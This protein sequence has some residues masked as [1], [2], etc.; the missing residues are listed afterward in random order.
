MSAK[1]SELP[2]GA[3]IVGT[4]T[5]P[6]VQS[7]ATVAFTYNQVKT[8]VLSGFSANGL[9]LGAAANYAAMRGLLDLEAGTDFNAYSANLAALSAMGST[10]LMARTGSGTYAART[11]TAPAAGITVTD[12]DG[13]AGNPTLAL[14]N[15]LAA[16]EALSGTNTIYYRSAANTWTAVTIGSG[17]TFSAGS[18]STTGG[19][20]VT[21]TGALTL[22][23]LVFG[24]GTD[25]LK[26]G[27]LT[28]D[29][30]TSGGTATT[31]G[32]LKVATGMI[33]AGAVTLAKIANA[34]A[35]SKLLGSGAAGSGSAYAELTL[36]TGLSFS[37]TTLNVSGFA[38]TGAITGSGLTMA[39][40]KL[41]G[42]GTASTGA[43][44]EITLGSNLSLSGT[45][46]NA[47]ASGG[48]G[49]AGS[50][51]IDTFSADGT[52]SKPS[53]A[54]VVKVYVLGSGGA[55]GSGAAGTNASNR[56][57][58]GGGAGGGFATTEFNASDLGSSVSV[59]VGAGG[60]APGGDGNTSSFG[61]FLAAR[62]GSGGGNGTTSGGSA[63]G[64]N[65]SAG[66]VYQGGSGAAGSNTGSAGSS[67]ATTT[68]NQYAGGAGG[69]GGG[70][71]ST[72]DATG[73][74]GAGG[75]PIW[76][77]GGGSTTGGGG[78]GGVAPT[79]PGTAGT[80]ADLSF[81]P[82][83]GGGGGAGSTTTTGGA[84]G[85]GGFGAGGG[86]GGASRSAGGAGGNGGP[87]RVWVVTYF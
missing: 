56:G 66:S 47:V 74:G 86:G 65:G 5:H 63:G 22:N 18:L 55:G 78:A 69:G 57:G 72:A 62:G 35:N 44:E 84:G 15:D 43:V 17:L 30:T 21:H 76:R 33:Q 51:Q 68:A 27:D 8:F 11:L 25:D 2:A 81:Q 45:T 32:A 46:L 58:G 31:I 16:L 87:G 53:G 80:S 75:Q 41:L 48:S 24:N 13:V 14:A 40:N 70:G 10:G 73:S 71:V 26:V 83:V 9:S 60:T 77:T 38:T 54:K 85:V 36:G 37:G 64:G 50:P 82:G 7:A 79:N 29:V 1:I 6:G 28:G 34:S 67:A 12:G 61:S 39:T 52:W 59:T 42:R 49:V 20:T 23:Q 3:T 4:E 19:G